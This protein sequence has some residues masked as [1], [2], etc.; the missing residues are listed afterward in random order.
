[1]P[2]GENRYFLKYLHHRLCFLT[3]L[4]KAVILRKDGFWHA[5]V[6]RVIYYLTKPVLF[7]IIDSIAMMEK[8]K[9]HAL[10]QEKLPIGWEAAGTS[11]FENHS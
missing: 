2:A 6:Q 9:T 10:S 1:M 8:S 11:L 4:W 5:T 7:S 3:S